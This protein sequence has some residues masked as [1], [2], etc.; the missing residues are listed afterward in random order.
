VIST[1]VHLTETRSSVAVV[2]GGFKSV[3]VYRAHIS[4]LKFA[5]AADLSRDGLV[6]TDLHGT[7]AASFGSSLTARAPADRLL[8]ATVHI[9][10]GGLDGRISHRGRGSK[11]RR[12]GWAVDRY[13]RDRC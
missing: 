6:S 8:C 5:E 2:N 10:R 7:R 12:A 1:S 3:G 9:K 13:R 4:P 11:H